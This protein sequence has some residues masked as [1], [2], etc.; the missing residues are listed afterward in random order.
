MHSD[1]YKA[2][3]TSL[4]DLSKIWDPFIVVDMKGLDGLTVFAHILPG[5]E[6][7]GLG[8]LL[9][10]ALLRSIHL[11]SS[12]L[13]GGDESI[14]GMAVEVALISGILG[15]YS[16]WIRLAPSFFT[17]LGNSIMVAS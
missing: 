16:E 14:L 6:K 9:L 10:M 1:L 5:V 13:A 8:M 7:L 17:G 3:V 12:V 11:L 2:A 15:G 4:S